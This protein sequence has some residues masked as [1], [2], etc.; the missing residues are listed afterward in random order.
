MKCRVQ[1]M[2]LTGKRNE[3]GGDSGGGSCSGVA[4]LGD[5]RGESQGYQL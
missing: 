5:G 3:V 1:N 4:P 2:L